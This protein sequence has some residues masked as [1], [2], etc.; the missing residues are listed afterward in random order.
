MNTEEIRENFT[1][2]R[3]SDF[4]ERFNKLSF[5]GFAPSIAQASNFAWMGYQ[6]AVKDMDGKS[7]TENYINNLKSER[8]NAMREVADL[9][10]ERNELITLL[11]I[12]ISAIDFSSATT[13][14]VSD[15]GQV[16]KDKYEALSTQGDS[17]G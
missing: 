8:A 1:K 11:E 7:Y 16:W 4:K 3:D 12:A 15:L 9:T 10:K 2:W 14:V 5:V 6:Q 13:K 17:D